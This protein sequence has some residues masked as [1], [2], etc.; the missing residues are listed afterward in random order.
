M[1]STL[2]ENCGFLAREILQNWPEGLTCAQIFHIIKNEWGLNVSRPQVSA[3]LVWLRKQG[4]VTPIS[5]P[6]P[7][8]YTFQK[9]GHLIEYKMI[10]WWVP[11]L[12]RA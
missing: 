2:T 1:T 8:P 12:C 11:R 7:L 5:R 9:R 6:W 3:G 4:E 10:N